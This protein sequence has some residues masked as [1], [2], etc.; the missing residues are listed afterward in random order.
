MLQRV[1][2]AF[3]SIH[4]SRTHNGTVPNLRLLT[5]DPSTTSVRKYVDQ[6]TAIDLISNHWV[7]TTVLGPNASVA[8]VDD[9]LKVFGTRNIVR[10]PTN[11]IF[12]LQPI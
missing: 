9:N 10:D 11:M 5:P 4:P 2:G 6:A 1:V 7:G 8:V 3:C 12:R